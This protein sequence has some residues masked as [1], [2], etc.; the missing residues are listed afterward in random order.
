MD[1]T[2]TSIAPELVDERATEVQAALQFDSEDDRFAVSSN[3]PIPRAADQFDG[4]GRGLIL[5]IS[6]ADHV[7][8]YPTPTGR[9]V[10]AG[11]D[12]TRAPHGAVIA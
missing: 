5:V 10:R 4:D 11:M 3:P 6:E 2:T 1:S 12:L 8:Y 9:V 7:G